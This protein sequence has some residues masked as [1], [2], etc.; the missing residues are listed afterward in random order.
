[1]FWQQSLII[2]YLIFL[3]LVCF[4]SCGNV[5]HLSEKLNVFFPLVCFM[6]YKKIMEISICWSWNIIVSFCVT[7]YVLLSQSHTKLKKTSK[8]LKYQLLKAV[9]YF[10]QCSH[11]LHREKW[12]G[13]QQWKKVKSLLNTNLVFSIKQSDLWHCQLFTCLIL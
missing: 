9:L 12:K 3:L 1:M 5:D 4:I 10:C 13:N 11:S 7:S 6:I 2:L 8:G